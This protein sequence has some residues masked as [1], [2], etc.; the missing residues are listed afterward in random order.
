MVKARDMR[1]QTDKELKDQLN[2]LRQQLS[3]LQI[4]RLSA[5]HGTKLSKI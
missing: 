1:K 4:N 3:E 2:S 5:A